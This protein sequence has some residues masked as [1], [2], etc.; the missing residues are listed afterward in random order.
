M[1]LTQLARRLGF[2]EGFCL[3][4]T[5]T[6]SSASTPPSPA[7]RAE[8]ARQFDISGLAGLQPRRVRGAGT[9][10]WPVNWCGLGG[11]PD[12]SR[13]GASA[14]PDARARLLPLAQHSPLMP[15]APREDPP[16]PQ[17]RAAA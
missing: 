10:S 6:R 1:A 5:S 16:A 9:L 13:T 12:C 11:G 17:Q 2:G 8:G 4:S 15:G 14:T 3:A 7:S